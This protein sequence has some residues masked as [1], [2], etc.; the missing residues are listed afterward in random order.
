MHPKAVCANLASIASI[1]INHPPKDVKVPYYDEH[2]PL[3]DQPNSRY[4][5]NVSYLTFIYFSLA[6]DIYHDS[7]LL[8]LWLRF[9]LRHARPML[10]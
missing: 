8:F 10:L 3:I 9:T 7:F 6:V 4:L 2:F 1:D 5:E